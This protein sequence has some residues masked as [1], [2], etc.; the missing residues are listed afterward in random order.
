M[1]TR[2]PSLISRGQLNSKPDA[3]AYSKRGQ[4]YDAMNNPEQAIIEYTKAIE[5]APAA[6]REGYL[7][8]RALTYDDLKK[9]GPALADLTL[10]IKLSPNDP[11]NHKWR[12]IIRGKT[13]D[14]DAGLK[15]LNRA[16]A[17]NPDANTYY[18]RGKLYEKMGK[19]RPC[20]CRCQQVNRP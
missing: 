18:H 17:L 12:G 1:T 2:G 7:F 14:F 13:G 8:N 10:A 15:D 20:N 3:F 6:E 4:I 11:L 5:I 19:Q 16:I 9:Y